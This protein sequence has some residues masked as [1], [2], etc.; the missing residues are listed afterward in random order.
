M[1]TQMGLDADTPV[2]QLGPGYGWPGPL[3]VP[4]V[5]WHLTIFLD[6]LYFFFPSELICECHLVLSAL[7]LLILTICFQTFCNEHFTMKLKI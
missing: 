4:L 5:P 1:N 6:I 3:L 7:L 2:T